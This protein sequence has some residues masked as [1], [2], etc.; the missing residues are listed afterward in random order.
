MFEKLTT[1]T[2]ISSESCN[3]NCSYCEIAKNASPSH[4]AEAEKVREALGSGIYFNRYRELFANYHIDV[5]QI[6]RIEL[7]GQEPTLTLNEFAS[8][9]PDI[10]DWLKK[11]KTLFF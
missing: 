1:V 8:Q 4:L 10:F 2:F 5:D 7:W 6:N 9:V 11:A 3:L